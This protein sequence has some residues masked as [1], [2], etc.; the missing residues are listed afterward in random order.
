M[1]LKYYGNSDIVGK[2]LP[3]TATTK[4]HKYPVSLFQCRPGIT[5]MHRYVCVFSYVSQYSSVRAFNKEII[6]I[7]EKQNEGL[8]I[9]VPVHV[10]MS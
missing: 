2:F 7:Q 5:R 10:T 6:F 4:R 3:P 1:G 8:I 9:F